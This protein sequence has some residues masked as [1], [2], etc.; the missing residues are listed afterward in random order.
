M[1]KT[2]L[3]ILAAL[4]YAGIASAQSPIGKWQTIDDETGKPKSIVEIFEKDGKLFGKIV[5]LVREEGDDPN[6][7]CDECPKDDPRYKQPVIGME[8]IKDL[9]QDGDEWEDGTVLDPEKGKVYD[10]KIWMEDDK[11]LKLRGYVAFFYRT[12]TWKKAE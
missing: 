10:C 8:I 7:L 12:Q 1:K 3:S 2:F 9:E 5:E 11:T 6:P 4:L